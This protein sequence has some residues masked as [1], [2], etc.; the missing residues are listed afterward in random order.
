MFR[1]LLCLVF[2]AFVP[3][4]ASAVDL[5][6][7]EFADLYVRTVEKDLI[8]AMLV[9]M[10]NALPDA[11]KDVARLRLK[12]ELDAAL[13]AIIDDTTAVVITPLQEHQ[14]NV[15]DTTLP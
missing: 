11:T 3:V 13:Q 4:Q 14:A 5:P 12:A 15:G 8:A 6:K 1:I 10:Y 7:A 9:D 2:L